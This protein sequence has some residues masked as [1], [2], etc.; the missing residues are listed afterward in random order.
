MKFSFEPENYRKKLTEEILEKRKSGDSIGAYDALKEEEKSLE[1]QVA[2]AITIVKRNESGEKTEEQIERERKEVFAY[3]EQQ[4]FDVIDLSKSIPD[5][6]NILIDKTRL[7]SL[8]EQLKQSLHFKEKKEIVARYLDE[9]TN[10]AYS[11][12]RNMHH[13]VDAQ[14]GRGVGKI[15]EHTKEGHSYSFL[16]KPLNFGLNGEC[17]VSAGESDQYAEENPHKPLIIFTLN[18]PVFHKILKDQYDEDLNQYIGKE[19]VEIKGEKFYRINDHNAGML[20]NAIL[21]HLPVENAAP[22]CGSYFKFNN[23][24]LLRVLREYGYT[25]EDKSVFTWPLIASY[26]IDLR[27]WFPIRWL[28]FPL[29]C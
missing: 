4:G 29:W 2:K 11:D 19:I 26:I 6:L 7:F 12:P 20:P 23:P 22:S 5:E 28:R 21:S 13:V 3:M 8:G 9:I 1:Y 16:Y 24:K 17:W 15:E 18:N 14:Y 25:Q 10:G 27:H